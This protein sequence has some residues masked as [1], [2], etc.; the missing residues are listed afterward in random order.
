MVTGSALRSPASRVLLAALVFL[1]ATIG[2][3]DVAAITTA[4]P[5]HA[6]WLAGALPAV[7]SAVGLLGGALYTR[8][9]PVPTRRHLLLA[10]LFTTAWL[11]LL[12][13]LP[14]RPCSP[15]PCCPAPCSSRCSPRPA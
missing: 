11:P 2:T 14:V 5:H 13:P 9:Q 10:A 15:W 8:H 4:G 12:A 3:L 6:A 1:G 7:F